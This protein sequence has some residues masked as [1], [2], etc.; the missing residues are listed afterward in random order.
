MLHSRSRVR[1]LQVV[2][3]LATL[4]RDGAPG[5]PESHVQVNSLS[6][7]TLLAFRSISLGSRVPE[8]SLEMLEGRDQKTVQAR[9]VHDESV[10]AA[11]RQIVGGAPCALSL[12]AQLPTSTMVS[13]TNPM[14]PTILGLSDLHFIFRGTHAPTIS[15]RLLL[16]HRPFG[17]SL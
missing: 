5:A 7:L 15:I 4:Y 16:N 3:Y 6:H 13:P 17:S 1:R 10:L 12:S 8:R 9:R 11:V 14:N 2:T